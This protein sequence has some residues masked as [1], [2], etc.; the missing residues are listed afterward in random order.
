MKRYSTAE[1]RCLEI[2][3]TC[4][5]AK[6]GRA[7][8]FEFEA[9]GDCTKI[10]ALIIRGRGGIFG[11][12]CEEDLRIPWCNVRCIGE[13]IIL[14]ELSTQDCDCCCRPRKRFGRRF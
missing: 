14:V 6:L 3:N 8:D 2:V 5:G 4:D 7:S 10:T 11:F 12:G 13:D 1:L 9:D